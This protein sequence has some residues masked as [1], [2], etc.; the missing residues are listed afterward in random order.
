MACG[1]CVCDRWVTAFKLSPN[2]R[3]LTRID[4]VKKFRESEVDKLDKILIFAEKSEATAA[5]S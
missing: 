4:D 3:R 2:L 1:V 5:P